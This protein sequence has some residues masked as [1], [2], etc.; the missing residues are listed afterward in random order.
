MLESLRQG[1]K[2]DLGGSMFERRAGWDDSVDE[3]MVK[4]WEVFPPG[5]PVL[6]IWG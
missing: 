4:E 5:V 2:E 6:D 3:R 1:G